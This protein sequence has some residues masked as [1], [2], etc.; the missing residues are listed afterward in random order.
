MNGKFL[1][2]SSSELYSGLTDTPFSEYMIGNTG[3]NHPRAVYIEGKRAGECAVNIARKENKVH[4]TSVRL[5]LAYGPGT[6]K[7]D[8]RVLNNLISKA[9]LENRI[10][11]LD[12]GNSIRT[13]CYVSDA[14]EMIF[15]AMIHGKNPV[16]NIGGKSRVTIKELA[17]KISKLTNTEITIP[18]SDNGLEGAPL[19]VQLN[20]DSILEIFPKNSFVDISDGLEKT[21]SWQI[22]N[23]YNI[24]EVK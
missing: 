3:P 1:F 16:Y 22:S 23:I 7:N 4:A 12:S 14:V 2:I 15:G 9:I 19:D 13:Y 10:K 11:L 18:E 5:S 6:K 17:E 21:I 20:I 24:K 8:S